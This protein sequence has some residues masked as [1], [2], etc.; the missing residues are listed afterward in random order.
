LMGAGCSRAH[1]QAESVRIVNTRMSVRE[2]EVSG[3]R[4]D[5]AHLAAHLQLS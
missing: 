1:S 5:Q 4:V 3:Q 2:G